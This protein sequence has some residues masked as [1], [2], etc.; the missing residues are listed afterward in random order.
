MTRLQSKNK[1]L[2]PMKVAKTKI[3]NLNSTA[4]SKLHGTDTILDKLR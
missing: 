1:T 2:R 3:V 4:F